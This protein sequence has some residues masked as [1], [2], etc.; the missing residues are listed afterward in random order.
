MLVGVIYIPELLA[1]DD[2]NIAIFKDGI[3]SD[4]TDKALTD[5]LYDLLYHA[6]FIDTSKQHLPE[7][8]DFFD[9]EE[10]F[11]PFRGS[12]ISAIR[13]RSVPTFG[14][15]VY[16]TTLVPGSDIVKVAN[17]AHTV[18][19]KSILAQ[20][21][22]F[23]PND[24][25][26]PFLLSDNER[27]LRTLPFIRDARIYIKPMTTDTSEVELTIVTQDIFSIGIGGS[28]KSASSFN[29]DIFD[30]NLFGMGW[31]FNN[32]FRYRSNQTPELGYDG[33]FY[34]NNIRGTFISGTLSYTNVQ[35]REVYG[36]SFD[37]AFLT[38]Q[39]K[40]AGGLSFRRSGI[41]TL[42]NSTKQRFYRINDTD[43]WFGRAFQI[44]GSESRRNITFALRYNTFNYDVRPQINPDSNFV[45]HNQD[46]IL[47]SMFYSKIYYTTSN[48][49]RG[50]GRTEDIPIGYRIDITGGYSNGEIENRQYGSMGISGGLLLDHLGYLSANFQFG[51][52]YD[53]HRLENGVVTAGLSY[54]TPLIQLDGFR[55]RQFFY[56]D[57][58]IGFN[59]ID[60]IL[61][62]L[63]DISGIR[64]LTNED[65]TG[66]Q[67][68]SLRF[69]SVAFSPWNWL[70]FRFALAGFFD[71]GF[72]GTNYRVPDLKNMYSSLGLTLRLRNINLVIDT[73]EI[74][75]AF[76]PR[77]PE[78]A[79][80]VTWHFSTTEQRAFTSLQGRKPTLLLFR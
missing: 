56:S 9:S 77:V 45:Y 54:F 2:P 46:M 35:E 53:G 37:K 64:W 23:A 31:E 73:F 27:I 30:R 13:F 66:K 47:A 55:F 74:G 76:Y 70:G 52:Y 57:Y 59:R 17:S 39:T 18:T 78:G 41:Y 63:K 43:L 6:V 58:T 12:R 5:D 61:I 42:S 33:R 68:L 29:F 48:L 8:R 36:I 44:G 1:A 14:G 34:V 4:T 16:D 3:E 40:Y 7:R 28:V 72:I 26:E 50:F 19:Q 80:P 79:S 71:T 51:A 25:V 15:S 20:N 60:E 75:F 67:R 10:Y 38:P 24:T 22:I 62:E 11:I 32:G 65:F 49:V 69:E 21:L